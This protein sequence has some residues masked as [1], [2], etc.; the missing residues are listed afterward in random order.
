MQQLEITKGK[1]VIVPQIAKRYILLYLDNIQGWQT[2]REV[3]TNPESAIQNFI[4][5]QNKYPN[6]DIEFYKCIEVDLQ[7]PFVP[8]NE[9]K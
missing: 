1:S 4:E 6:K 9:T 2:D 7:I 3:F 5:R 8:K